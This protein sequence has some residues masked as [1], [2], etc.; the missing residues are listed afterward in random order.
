V[1]QSMRVSPCTYIKS[2]G[3]CMRSHNGSK[4]TTLDLLLLSFFTIPLSMTSPLLKNSLID[5]R[6]YREVLLARNSPR[7]PPSAYSISKDIFLHILKQ[8]FI[9]RTGWY[10]K[11]SKLIFFAGILRRFPKT[12]E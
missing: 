2:N 7:F 8:V 1:I 5:S 3:D 9:T 11:V 4:D 10:K 12:T 6:H